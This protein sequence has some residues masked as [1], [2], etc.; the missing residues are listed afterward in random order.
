MKCAYLN[1]PKEVSKN[2][3]E[4]DEKEMEGIYRKLKKGDIVDQNV[5]NTIIVGGL[6]SFLA[7]KEVNQNLEAEVTTLETELKT[8]H[9]TFLI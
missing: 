5:V 2:V 8:S 4:V 3:M 6:I 1:K 7:Q 9:Q